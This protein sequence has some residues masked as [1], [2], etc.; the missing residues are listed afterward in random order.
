MY[1]VSILLT[2]ITDVLRRWSLGWVFLDVDNGDSYSNVSCPS[3]NPSLCMDS[4]DHDHIFDSGIL[5]QAK[6]QR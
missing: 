1:A 5:V 6:K 3:T 2:A 4:C